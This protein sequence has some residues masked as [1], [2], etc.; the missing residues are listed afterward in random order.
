MSGYYKFL[1]NCRRDLQDGSFESSWWVE[2]CKNR[3]FWKL[4]FWKKLWCFK[5]FTGSSATSSC[6]IDVE[7]C[8]MAHSKALDAYINDRTGFF[9]NWC[10]EKVLMF[11]IFRSFLYHKFLSN[12]RRDLQDGSFESPCCVDYE[13]DRFPANEWLEYKLWQSKIL[14]IFDWENFLCGETRGSVMLSYVS[15]YSVLPNALVQHRWVVLNRLP[16]LPSK[17]SW[18]CGKS[19]F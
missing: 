5:V 16:E 10:F 11:Q 12:C 1:P 15:G 19:V 7:T 9:E 14:I 18:L 4:M 2:K 13:C 6:L 17:S 3:F 8:N